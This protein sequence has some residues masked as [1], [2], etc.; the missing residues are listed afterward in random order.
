MRFQYI[1][2]IIISVLL[3]SGCIAAKK[4]SLIRPD[5][6]IYSGTLS[7]D[8]PYSGNIVI[9]NGPNNE[10]F[11]G[12]FVVVDKTAVKRNQGSLIVPQGNTIPAFGSTS[13]TSSGNVDASGYWYATG[14]NGSHM[15]CT[16]IIGIGGHGHGTC[17]HDNGAFYEIML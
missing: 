13:G 17:K 8:G 10:S 2:L 12:T 9:K 5:G 11:S 7:Y 4:V 16:L 1:Y 14:N 3:L 6:Q 15:K